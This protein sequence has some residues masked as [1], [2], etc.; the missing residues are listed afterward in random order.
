[1]V[2]AARAAHRQAEPHGRGR[3]HAIHD[4][5][6]RILLRDDAALGVATVVAVEAGG[7][8]LF[9][10][11]AGQQITRELLYGKA[12]EGQVAVERVDHPVAPAPHGAFAVALVA[13]G[14]GVAG[15]VEPTAGHA[16]AVTVGG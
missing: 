9:A 11:R 12:V 2:M 14:V 4:I 3:V 5:L 13:V 16:L 1:M 7:D 10:R 6:G 8:V 15:R